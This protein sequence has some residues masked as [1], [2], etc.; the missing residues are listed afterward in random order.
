M[1]VQVKSVRSAS[2]LS[3]DVL[4]IAHIAALRVSMFKCVVRSSGTYNAVVLIRRHNPS[5]D[6]AFIWS[7]QNANA[8]IIAR[9]TSVNAEYA[10]TS[11]SA[12]HN[13]CGEIHLLT[14]NKV[15]IPCEYFRGKTFRWDC[16]IPKKFR[17]RALSE[18]QNTRYSC[19]HALSNWY[20]VEE[21]F[22]QPGKA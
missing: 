19:D 2:S 8:G 9:K 20:A 12:S 6:L 13:A 17:R 16:R 14:S 18:Q 15:G 3:L 5:L 22:S 10:V 4:T 7:F 1:D 21:P 11:W